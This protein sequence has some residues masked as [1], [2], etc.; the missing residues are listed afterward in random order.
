MAAHVRV[1]PIYK[2]RPKLGKNDVVV[3]TVAR[4][5]E[6]W[7][8]L[9]PF[10]LGPC[11]LYRSD[12]RMLRS[13]NM[14]NAWQYAKVYEQHTKG[15]DRWPYTAIPSPEY[16][17]WAKAG[18]MN[19]KAARYPMGKGVKPCFSWW[20]GKPLNYI[21]ARKAI[22]GPLYAEQVLQTQAWENLYSLY[23][24]KKTLI[25]L[26]YDA[27]D[28]HELGMSLTDVLNDPKRKMGHAFVLAMLLTDDP[29]L[30]QMELRDA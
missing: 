22:Y 26:D 28:H 2:T 19:P 29:A 15:L 12:G 14:E 13:K 1:L 20:K 16:W 9:S 6:L 17:K 21:N 4:A 30:E 18:W 11:D 27:Y 10:I 5:G 24:K 7:S 8:N 3:S 23:F 25:L